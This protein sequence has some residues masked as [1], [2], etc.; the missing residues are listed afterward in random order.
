M[1]SSK[2]NTCPSCRITNVFQEHLPT[3][4]EIEENNSLSRPLPGKE[5]NFMAVHTNECK[6]QNSLNNTSFVLQK[7]QQVSWTI[8]DRLFCAF[9]CA[10]AVVVYWRGGWSMMDNMLL[11]ERRELS[12]WIS[13]F[14]GFIINCIFTLM[15]N[16]FAAIRRDSILFILFSR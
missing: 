6:R 14:I 11:P 4:C 8:A 9:V 7:C 5:S 13:L 15:Q 3:S 10:P 16:Q 1:S 12:A 2:K